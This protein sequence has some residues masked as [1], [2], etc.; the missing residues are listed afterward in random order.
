MDKKDLKNKII[1]ILLQPF[2]HKEGLRLTEKTAFWF[3]NQIISEFKE[4]ETDKKEMVKEIE[5]WMVGRLPAFPPKSKAKEI[6]K[7]KLFSA[8][9]IKA[10]LNKL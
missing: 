4:K 6:L 8:E 7:M 2:P 1:D 9:D 10:F 3:A 5:K